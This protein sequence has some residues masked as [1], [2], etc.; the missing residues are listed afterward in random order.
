MTGPSLASAPGHLATA[1]VAAGLTLCLASLA[2]CAAPSGQ[3]SSASPASN[4]PSI[5]TTQEAEQMPH[6][7]TIGPHE[8]GGTVVLRV[9]DRLDVAPASR[10]R[11]WVVVEVPTGIL[12]LN[13]SPGAA[14]SHALIAVAVGEGQL[15]LRPAGPEARSIGRYSVRIHVVRNIVQGP[16]SP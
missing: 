8:D 4:G 7:R 13:G 3:Q 12:R 9:G 16:G 1:T 15:T 10:A 6:L 2:G 11:G 5:G 14:A